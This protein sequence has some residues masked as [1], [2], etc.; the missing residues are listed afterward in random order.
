[1]SFQGVTLVI[2]VLELFIVWMSIVKFD[3]LKRYNLSF[4][5]PLS[6]IAL[7]VDLVL[8]FLKI[9]IVYSNYNSFEIIALILAIKNLKALRLYKLEFIIPY[10]LLY[11]VI[12]IIMGIYQNYGWFN[13]HFSNFYNL[14]V[15]I[16]YFM[17]FF[18]ILDVKGKFVK[19]YIVL[20]V[21]IFIGFAIEFIWNNDPRIK[22][23]IIT[24]IGINILSI[25]LSGIVITRLITNTA[26]KKLHWH[27]YFW[28]FLGLLFESLM[29]LISESLHA[30]LIAN[31]NLSKDFYFVYLAT[32]Y[33]RNILD[34]SLMIA[35]MLCIRS[36][37]LQNDTPSNFNLDDPYNI[38]LP[39]TP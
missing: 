14:T 20:S 5:L 2:S 35:I 7:V 10:I 26:V 1:M 21:I 9:D 11:F 37:H 17:M 18:R 30:Y 36:Y 28:L 19:L 8:Y 15:S 25:L 27:P 4:F 3:T 16:I 29:N 39:K 24:A 22:N 34:I 32:G 13:I 23:N 38:S 31:L 33:S 12:D 6:I